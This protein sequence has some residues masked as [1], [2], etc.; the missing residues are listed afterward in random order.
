MATI[1]KAE[2]LEMMKEEIALFMDAMNEVIEEDIE[3]LLDFGNPEKVIGKPYDDWSRQELQ[4]ASQIYGHKL[5]DFIAKKSI[6][7]LEELE[8]EEV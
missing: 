3:P 2:L 5:E 6:A 7:L 4:R 8:A 1:K